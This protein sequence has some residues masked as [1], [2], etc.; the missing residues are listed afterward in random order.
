MSPYAYDLESVGTT[1][2]KKNNN[3]QSYILITSVFQTKRTIMTKVE[4]QNYYL[5]F[6]ESI[7]VIV[8]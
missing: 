8:K 6:Q 7:F 3:K 1:K 4:R 5:P 2:Q